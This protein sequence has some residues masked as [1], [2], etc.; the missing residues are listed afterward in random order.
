MEEDRERGKSRY[1]R[2]WI[3]RD[4]E[5]LID[6]RFLKFQKS[7]G[8]DDWWRVF[9]S[10]KREAVSKEAVD[11]LQMSGMSFSIVRIVKGGACG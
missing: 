10:F 11:E 3:K 2:R 7:I 9:Q 8:K 5:A 6:K 4:K 1:K